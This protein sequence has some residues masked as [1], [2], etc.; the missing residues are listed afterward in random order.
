MTELNQFDDFLNDDIENAPEVA[1]F[2]TPP[3]GY[4]NLTLTKIDMD[5]AEDSLAEW[6]KVTWTID[7]TEELAK[8]DA[9]QVKDGSLFSE[10][11]FTK[12]KDGKASDMGRGAL[13]KVFAPIAAQF[14]KTQWAEIFE[15]AVGAKVR[16]K[17]T[18][19]AGKKKTADGNVMYFSNTS[20]V[21]ML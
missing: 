2:V 17:I 15:A 7:C 14:G 21:S 20:D 16:A 4:Y 9:E 11:F 10:M 8:A 6:V 13:K 5:K 12:T 18:T 19:K 3:S 1:D